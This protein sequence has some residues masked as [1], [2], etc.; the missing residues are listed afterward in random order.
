MLQS[1]NDTWV[2]LTGHFE[3]ACFPHAAP[4]FF[5]S[6]SY[7]GLKCH[8][9]TTECPLHSKLSFQILHVKTNNNSEHYIHAHA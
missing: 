9:Q 2:Q 8:G 4:P 7:R 1:W 6:G 3:S 5:L